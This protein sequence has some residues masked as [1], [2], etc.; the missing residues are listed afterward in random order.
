MTFESFA[1]TNAGRR[2]NNEDALIHQPQLGVFGVADGMG[3]YEGGEVA[4]H[5]A[6]TAIES[7]YER[8]RQ[9]PEM[10]FPQ[11]LDVRR[12]LAENQLTVAIGLAHQAIT[13]Q[14]VGPLRDMG[15]TLAAVVVPPGG[16]QA[17]IGHVGDSR[18]Y[19]L[20]G[21]RLTQLTR[22]HSLYE[23]LKAAGGATEMPSKRDCPFANIIT[24][25]LGLKDCASPEVKTVAIQPGDLF[26]ICSDGLSDPLAESE[27]ARILGQ[28]SDRPGLPLRQA[29]QQLVSAAYAAGS[30]DNISA[31]T[32]WIRS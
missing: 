7:L 2:K 20:R 19:R 32:I 29:T 4:S 28:V 16:G 18:I 5:L 14:R 12:S 27:I 21:G 22:D 1:F 30:S 31:V 9:D 10:T 24:R 11:R 23:D 3:G 25:V 6:A 15:S 17:V 26:L 13:Q 8:F